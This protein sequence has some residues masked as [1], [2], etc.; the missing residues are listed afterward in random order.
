LIILANNLAHAVPVI[1]RL[2]SLNGANRCNFSTLLTLAFSNLEKLEA[3]LQDISSDELQHDKRLSMYTPVTPPHRSITLHQRIAFE[4]S[5]EPVQKLS[6]WGKLVDMLLQSCMFLDRKPPIWD[7]LVPRIL[8]W[9]S[10]RGDMG[11]DRDVSEWIRR[12]VIV[13]L[14]STVQDGPS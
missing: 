3:Q 12:E 4:T 14:Q 10:L 11:D 7:V 5:L 1:L 8:L 6:L 13:N 9:R 2:A